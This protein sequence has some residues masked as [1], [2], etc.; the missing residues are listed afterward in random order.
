MSVGSD[1]RRSC[2]TVVAFLACAA[3][4]GAC[5]SSSK[6]A[7]T[8]TTTTSSASPTTGSSATPGSALPSGV[9]WMAGF[10]APG[11]PAKYNKVGVIKVGPAG[12]KNVLVLE[13]GT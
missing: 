1:V 9:S 5:S 13:P 8:N 12:A 4:L 7:A 10:A 3:L 2:C 11:T 6:S